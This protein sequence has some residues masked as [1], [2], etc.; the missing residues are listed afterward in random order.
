MP[1]IL[2]RGA[3]R[4]ATCYIA[5]IAPHSEVLNL[6]P[7]ALQKA[8]ILSR[9]HLR[10]TSRKQKHERTVVLNH[11]IAVCSLHAGAQ[12]QSRRC[13]LRPKQGVFQPGGRI[14]ALWKENIG[15]RILL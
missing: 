2:L 12:G 14:T 15:T 5:T 8:S 13:R 10:A 3:P 9:Q 11:D 6:I 7:N 4:A 1:T